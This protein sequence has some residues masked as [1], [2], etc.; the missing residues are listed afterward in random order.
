MFGNL[1][2]GKRTLAAQV[3]IRIVKKNPEM[4]LKVVSEIDTITEDLESRHSTILIIHDPVKSWYT[5]KHTEYIISILLRICTSAKNKDNNFYVIAIF[6]CNDR[7]SHHFGKKKKT[8]ET[9]FPKRIPIYGNK[10]S[11]KLSDR[12]KDKQEDTSNVPFQKGKKSTEESFELTLFLKKPAF[13]H[14]VLDNPIMFII[15]ALKTLET[16][17]QNYKQL[18][19]KIIVI[20]MLRG[21][22]VAK[23]ELL[24]DAILYHELFLDLK[25]MMNVKESIIGCTEQLLEIFLE[26]TEDGRSYRILHDIILRCTFIVAFENHMTLLFKECD[27]ILI[28]ECLRLKPFE[29]RFHFPGNVIYDCS[30]LQ[31]GIPL[32]IFEEIARLFF[33]RIGM[34]SVLQKSRLYDERTFTDK[35]NKTEQ[36]FTDEI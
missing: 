26:E 25:E 13:Q 22:Q 36:H 1:G 24:G 11:V 5:D 16:S 17:N 21:G 18:A 23:S 31:I 9:L 27:S 32:Q 2:S 12:V 29:E 10:L 28:F 7:N 19:F 30:N 8:I 3:A 15:E 14:N 4:K 6:H 34:R 20:V 33:Q 35:W